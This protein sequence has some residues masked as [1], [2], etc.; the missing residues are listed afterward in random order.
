MVSKMKWERK[1]GE[2]MGDRKREGNMDDDGV[3]ISGVVAAV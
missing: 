2:A 1:K 3:G